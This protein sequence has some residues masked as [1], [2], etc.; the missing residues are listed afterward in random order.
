MAK[1]A[2]ATNSSEHKQMREKVDFFIKCPQKP[3]KAASF[4]TNYCLPMSRGF[5]NYELK[6]IAGIIT[7]IAMAD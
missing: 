3:R 7:A 6:R 1:V 5:E 2:K 4:Y